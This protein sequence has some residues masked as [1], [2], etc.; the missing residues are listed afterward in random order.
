MINHFLST[1]QMSQQEIHDL[2][3][4]AQHY[5]GINNGG[6]LLPLDTLRGKM[7]GLLFFE[8][9]T[10]TK[11]SFERAAKN[12]GAEVVELQTASSSLVKG[13]S[14]LDTART[15]QAMGIS[16]LV[17]RHASSGIPEFLAQK[18]DIPVINAGDGWHQHPTQAMLDLLTIR[19]EYDTLAGRKVLFVGD[20]RHSRVA[21]SNLFAMQAMGLKVQMAGPPT[22]VPPEMSALGAELVADVDLA[23]AEAD[24][25]YLLRIQWERQQGGLLPSLAEYADY[26]GINNRRL[27]LMKKEA[28][29][30]HPGPVNVG[31]ELSAAAYDSP[32][33]RIIKQINN[34]VAVRMAVLDRVLT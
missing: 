26:Y 6:T 13:E 32:R 25:V 10:R 23:L 29:I 18:L 34:G 28:I 8:P 31:V 30:M 2:L 3:N 19:Q 21:R 20:I 5:H 27:E 22:L 12:L 16:A 14:V 4:A 24:V 11:S 17:V 15:L 9:S 7:V 33:S 1:Y